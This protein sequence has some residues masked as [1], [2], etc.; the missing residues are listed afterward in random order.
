M[1]DID[2]FMFIIVIAAFATFV[3]FVAPKIN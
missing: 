3:I 1:K 2:P